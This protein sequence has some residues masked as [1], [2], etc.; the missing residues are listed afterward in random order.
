MKRYF[1]L[2]IFCMAAQIAHAQV[3][4]KIGYETATINVVDQDFFQTLQLPEQSPVCGFYDRP[5]GNFYTCDYATYRD[6]DEDYVQWNIQNVQG[7]CCASVDFNARKYYGPLTISGT[8]D[9]VEWD[10]LIIQFTTDK[11]RITIKTDE[12]EIDALYKYFYKGNKF[13]GKRKIVFELVTFDNMVANNMDYPIK[14]RRIKKPQ[15]VFV[16]WL[17]F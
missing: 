17:R 2:F 13:L 11:A 1:V 9:T 15:R 14:T 10:N 3:P 7:S 16:K 8:I 4:Y 12:K 5:S 6:V